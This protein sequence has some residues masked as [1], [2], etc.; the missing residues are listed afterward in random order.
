MDARYSEKHDNNKPRGIFHL[1]KSY[2]TIGKVR[3]LEKCEDDARHVAATRAI[4]SPFA[5][6]PPSSIECRTYAPTSC[7]VH[8]YLTLRT[9]RP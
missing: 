6:S 7:T 9:L 2:L 8:T 5:Y 3:V 1:D 4:P